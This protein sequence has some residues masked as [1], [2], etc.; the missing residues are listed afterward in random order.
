MED[1]RIQARAVRTTLRRVGNIL[2]AAVLVLALVVNVTDPSSTEGVLSLAVTLATL[3]FLAHVAAH[4]ASNL[5]VNRALS[6]R[7]TQA[8]A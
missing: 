1:V 6:R 7:S 2:A 8:Q 4:V 3:G 5:I